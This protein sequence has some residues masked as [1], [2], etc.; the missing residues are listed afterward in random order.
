MLDKKKLNVKD[1]PEPNLNPNR[2]FNLT[3]TPK[4]ST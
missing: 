3:L 2:S 4:R 1:K